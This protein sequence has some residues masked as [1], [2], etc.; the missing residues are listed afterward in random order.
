MSRFVATVSWLWSWL[1]G[2]LAYQRY[3]AHHRQAHPDVMPHSRQA[4]YLQAIERRYDGVN[5]CC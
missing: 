4:F 5:R 2:D 3:L 1:N